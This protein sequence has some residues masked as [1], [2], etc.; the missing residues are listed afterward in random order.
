MVLMKIFLNYFLMVC[1]IDIKEYYYTSL[2]R[3]LN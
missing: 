3:L 1:L 2:S